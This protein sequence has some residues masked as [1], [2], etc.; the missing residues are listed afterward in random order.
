M[1]LKN[2][3]LKNYLNRTNDS[4]HVMKNQHVFMQHMSILAIV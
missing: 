2:S 3:S 4:L 1:G